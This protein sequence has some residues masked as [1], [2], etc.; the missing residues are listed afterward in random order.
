MDTQRAYW[1]AMTCIN[2]VLLNTA[3]GTGTPLQLTARKEYHTEGITKQR[4]SIGTGC[5]HDVLFIHNGWYRNTPESQWG[6]VCWGTK[7]WVLWRVTPGI[8]RWHVPSFATHSSR[9]RNSLV[10]ATNHACTWS[11][12]YH[13][14]STTNCIIITMSFFAVAGTH[15]SLDG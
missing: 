1:H 14:W 9:T 2:G 8:L 11:C 6:Y 15:C 5:H 7:W 10:S 13:K 4:Y 12:S 3:D